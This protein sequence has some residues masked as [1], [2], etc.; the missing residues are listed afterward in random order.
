MVEIDTW[1]D[2]AGKN[3]MRRDW[4]IRDSNSQMIITRATRC[5][6]SSLYRRVLHTSFP[7]GCVWNLNSC[8]RNFFD[9]FK[10]TLWLSKINPNTVSGSSNFDSQLFVFCCSTWVIM[11]RETRRLSKIPDEVKKEVQP[12]YLDRMSIPTVD[13][14]GEKIDKLTDETADRIRS[15]LAVSIIRNS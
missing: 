1:V 7:L 9:M 6:T 11:N 5:S 10:H 4:I 8:K 15:G 14:D 12:F 2:A 13:S 3:G